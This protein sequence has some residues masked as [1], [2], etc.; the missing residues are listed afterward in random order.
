[1]RKPHISRRF[2]AGI[3]AVE[4]A[5]ILPVIV[6]VFLGLVDLARGMQANMILINLGREAANLSA[7][8]KVQLSDNA[9]TIIGQV[10]ATAPPLDMNKQG[11]LYITRVMGQTS[12][13]GT[14][15]IVLEQYRWDDSVNNRGFRV[16]GYA[17]TS[18]VWSCGNWASGVAGTC[19]V[20]SGTNAPVI[21]L[22]SGQLADGEVIYVVEAFY[23]FNMVFSPVTLGSA[24]TGTIGPD[25]YSMS[26][27]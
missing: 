3:A 13:S 15:S 11:M 16:S 27:F 14:R 4:L 26:V 17:P 22:M 20:P 21:T 9:Q 5:L 24:G 1:M 18:K 12:G 10:A 6:V 23:K 25:L 2:A 7:R 19:V 8:G